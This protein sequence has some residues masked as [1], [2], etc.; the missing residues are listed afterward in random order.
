MAQQILDQTTEQYTSCEQNHVPVTREIEEGTHRSFPNY[1]QDKHL[2]SNRF[3]ASIEI[4]RKKKKKRKRAKLFPTHPSHHHPP[5]PSPTV[6]E[7]P[8]FFYIFSV[9]VSTPSDGL[10]SFN[11]PA[12]VNYP[13]RSFPPARAG[14]VHVL[15]IPR[16][17]R[18]GA[19]LSRRERVASYR[20]PTLYRPILPG[21]S[22]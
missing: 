9:H 6:N 17:Y 1:S 10:S 8:I 13:R 4:L 18:V 16:G 21:R 14:C 19:V 2:D 3:D 22:D 7:F 5:N 12:T 20:Q 11:R 15:K